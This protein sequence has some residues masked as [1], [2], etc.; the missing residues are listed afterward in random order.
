M[1]DEPDIKR[2]TPY[3]R[4]PVDIEHYDTLAL[5]YLNNGHDEYDFADDLRDF[6]REKAASAPKSLESYKA[7]IISWLAENH[8]YLPAEMTRRLKVGGKSLTRDRAPT[9]EELRHILNHSDLQLK[10]YLLVLT[11]AGM[12]PGEGLGIEW[13]DVDLVTGKVHIR[14]EIAKSGEPRDTFLSIEA[15]EVLKQWQ[16]YHPAYAE[17]I[18]SY[19]VPV[20]FTRDTKRV[21]PLSYNGVRDKYGRVLEKCGLDEKDPTTGWLVLRLHVM[22]KFFRTRLPQGGASVDAVEQMLGHE[23]YCGG[24]YV[25]LTD[26][27]IETAYR[28]AESAL[29]IFKEPPYNKED[30]TRLERENQA[31]R[32]ELA[33]I[34]RQITMMNAMQADVG[35]TPEALQR[36]V[37]ARIRAMKS[38]G[39]I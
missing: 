27:E 23:G 11:S 3:I 14:R 13:P 28:G 5:E 24:A 25:R 31:L 32:G 17:K 39:E 20:E 21:F 29:W 18:D 9:L 10:A 19:T 8:V 33:G 38:S 15:L 2:A 26:E 4:S 30:L 1:N 7:A 35:A 37:D 6:L 22:R 12:R 36:L 34:Q 16:T